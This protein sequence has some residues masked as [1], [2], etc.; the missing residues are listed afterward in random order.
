VGGLQYCGNVVPGTPLGGSFYGIPLLG[1]TAAS[2]EYS[3]KTPDGKVYPFRDSRYWRQTYLSPYIQDDWKISKNLTLNL[4]L[5]YEWASNPTTVREPVFTIYNITSSA[6]T[7]DSFVAVKHPFDNNPNIKNIDPRIGL[8]WDPFGNHKTSVRAGFG[9]FHEPVTSRTYSNNNASFHPNQPLFFLFFNSDFPKLPS[10]PNQIIGGSP[11]NKQIAWYYA[12]LPDVDKAPYI[13][14]YNLTVQHE[15]AAGTVFTVGYNGSSGRNLFLWAN[16]N[17]PLAFSDQSASWRSTNASNWPGVTGQGPR[18][19]ISN[20]FVNIYT[21]P[22]F[23]AVEAVQPKARSSYHAMQTSLSR[24]FSPTLVGN[25]AYTWSKCLDNA[26][27]TN[28][29]EQGQWAVYNAYDP[30]FDRG[31]CSFNSNHVFTANALYRLP[32]KGNRAVEGWQLSTIISRYTGLPFNVQ[33][34]FGGMYQSQTGGA[35]EGERPNVVPGCNAMPKLRN[36]WY[37]PECFVYA[38]FGTLGNS[39]RNSL[40]KFQLIPTCATSRYKQNASVTS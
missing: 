1:I 35:T 25:I 10:S 30:D 6:T 34:Q 26:S 5:R 12:L 28:S 8:A 31:P 24:Q 20:P 40:N 2:D 9:T 23:Q 33:N 4:G 14:Q 15:L 27:G 17:K 11:A 7:P 19:T 29:S 39:S 16:A 21:N 13:M 38:P 3:Y 32:F 36:K 22:N 37:D 18:G